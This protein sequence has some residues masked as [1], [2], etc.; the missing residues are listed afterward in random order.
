MSILTPTNRERDR[1][2]HLARSTDDAD[3][4]GA[5]TPLDYL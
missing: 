5:S 2:E 3:S 1:L 4:S